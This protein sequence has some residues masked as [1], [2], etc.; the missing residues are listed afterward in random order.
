MQQ[1]QL[2]KLFRPESIALFGASDIP[3]KLGTVVLKNLRSAGFKGS[4]TLVNPK[5]QEI[6]GEPCLSSLAEAENQVDGAIIVTPARAVPKII[7][8]CGENGVASAIVISAGFR[9]AGPEGVALEAD[10]LRRAR[11]YGLRILGPNCLGV[12]RTDIGLNATF[13]AG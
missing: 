4:L 9:E 5:Y 11:R 8:E 2:K 3:G 13:S 10:M 12:I 1:E 7:T 6:D